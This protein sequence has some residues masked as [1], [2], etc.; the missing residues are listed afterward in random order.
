MQA[1]AK[2]YLEE[3]IFAVYVPA[4]DQS[5]PDILLETYS[6]IVKYQENGSAGLHMFAGNNPEDV[7]KVKSV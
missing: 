7:E 2:K 1:L 5:E 4:P 3:V 6:F